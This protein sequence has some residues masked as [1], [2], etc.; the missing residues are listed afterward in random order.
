MAADAAMETTLEFSTGLAIADLATALDAVRAVGRPDFRL[1][2]D[3]MHLVRSGSGPADVAVLDPALIGYIQLSDVPLVP[4]IADYM[5]EACFER[6][7][8]GTGEAPL[9]EIL[10]ALPRDRRDWNRGALALAGRR[11]CR[12]APTA[13]AMRGRHSAAPGPAGQPMKAFNRRREPARRLDSSLPT[14]KMTELRNDAI[15]EHSA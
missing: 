4:T 2:I 5:E 15:R 8:P 1:L 14:T 13:P 3:T 10:D 11:W 9:L 7:V 6:M 12:S